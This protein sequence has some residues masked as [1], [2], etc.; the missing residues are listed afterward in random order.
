[1]YIV[2]NLNNSV[3][4]FCTKN[5]FIFIF[6]GEGDFEGMFEFMKSQFFVKAAVNIVI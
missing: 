1:M 2:Y 3:L 6:K 4:M 5:G